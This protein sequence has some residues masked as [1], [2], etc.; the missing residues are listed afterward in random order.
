M[1]PRSPL[2]FRYSALTFNS[3][4]IHYDRDYAVDVEGYPGLVIHGPLQATLLMQFAADLRRDAMRKFTF[5]SGS[6]IFD[7][8]SFHLNAE[9][10]D[11][12]LSLWTNAVDGPAAMTAIAEW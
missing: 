11:G 7:T 6:P 3:H 5:R 12:G 2:L 8:Q 10:V 9:T 4:R 1:A